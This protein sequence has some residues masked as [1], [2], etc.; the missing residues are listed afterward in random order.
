LIVHVPAIVE[1]NQLAAALGQLSAESKR[2][3]GPGSD[4]PTYPLNPLH[5]GAY[6]AL[7]FA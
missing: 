3:N 7:A 1:T 4:D 6:N 2:T 5:E